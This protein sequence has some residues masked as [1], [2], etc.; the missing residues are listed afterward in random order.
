[1]GKRGL[2]VGRLAGT[3]K[4][5]DLPVRQGQRQRSAND[6]YERASSSQFVFSLSTAILSA[7]SQWC[8]NLRVLVYFHLGHT[9]RCLVRPETA[10]LLSQLLLHTTTLCGDKN[11]EHSG[12]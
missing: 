11:T 5:S 2:W 9:V 7:T 8:L 1:M 6:E 3:I 10:S 12:Q 4:G